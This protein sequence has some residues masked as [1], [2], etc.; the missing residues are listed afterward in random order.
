M[1]KLELA[2]RC[3]QVTGPDRELDELIAAAKVGATRELQSDGTTAYQVIIPL[4]HVAI[5]L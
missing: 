4:T 1:D 2:E 5:V 3:E